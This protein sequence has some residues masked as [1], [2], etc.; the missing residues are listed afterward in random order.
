M[1]V[2]M[3]A[4]VPAFNEEESIE[5]VIRNIWAVKEYQIDVLVVN[6]CSGDNTS[7]KCKDLGI[8]YIDLPCN[9]GIGGAMQTG[10][11]YA[12]KNGYD[13]ALQIDGDGQHNPQYIGQLIQP[14]AEGKADMVI[15]SRYI[16]KKGYQSTFMRRM[17]INYF[18]FLIRL[19]TG[20]TVKD[21]TSGFRACNK[22]VIHMFAHRYPQDY[23][24]PEA[25]VYLK[26]REF[27]LTEVSIEMS[28]RTGGKSSINPVKSIYFMI[29]V[30]MAIVI[31]R[32]RRQIV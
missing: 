12:S 31:D 30:S 4:I 24:E 25:I 14:L 3:L 10:Y 7:Q 26:R 17:G 9:L 11:K 16:D 32:F 20:E 6:D 8:K 27:K 13:I 18:S 5:A 22:K 28:Q 19:L 2:K 29:K 15:G 1:S 23:P 21:P